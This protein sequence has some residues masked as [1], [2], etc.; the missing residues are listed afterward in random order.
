MENTNIPAPSKPNLT[1][2]QRRYVVRLIRVAALVVLQMY[3]I[4]QALQ[5]MS[6]DITHYDG[7]IMTV[8]FSLIMEVIILSMVGIVLGVSKINELINH[9]INAGRKE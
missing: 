9:W 6:S 1:V 2:A 3:L 7:L 8:R 5:P 4:W